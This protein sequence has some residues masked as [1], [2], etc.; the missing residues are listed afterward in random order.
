M[1]SWEQTALRIIN[2][3]NNPPKNKFCLDR[4]FIDNINEIKKEISNL[5]GYE[6]SDRHLHSIFAAW[7]YQFFLTEILSRYDIKILRDNVNKLIKHLEQA[8][9]IH[10]ELAISLDILSPII[11]NKIDCDIS[12]YKKNLTTLKKIKNSI[13]KSNGAQCNQVTFTKAAYFELFFIAETLGLIPPFVEYK[14][15]DLLTFVEII[16]KPSAPTRRTLS[17]YY[18]KYIRAKEKVPKILNLINMGRKW[19]LDFEKWAVLL[20]LF[21]SIFCPKLMK[22]DAD[23]S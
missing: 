8:E 22:H 3:I 14:S 23:I 6:I 18:Q 4:Y 11:Q 17:D 10:K 21:Q 16:T 12:V 9:I 19:N 5:L 20:T 15:N 7:N 13:K 1:Y 2:K